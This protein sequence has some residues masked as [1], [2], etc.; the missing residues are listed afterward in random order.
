MTVEKIVQKYPCLLVLL[1]PKKHD[2]AGWVKDWTVLGT[3]RNVSGCDRAIEYYGREGLHS[4]VVFSTY[5]DD[6]SI[7]APELP[8]CHVAKFWRVF[9][10]MEGGIDDSRCPRT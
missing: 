3:V 9:F 5:T 10:G 6:P 2:D 4:V 1:T 8:P 7:Q